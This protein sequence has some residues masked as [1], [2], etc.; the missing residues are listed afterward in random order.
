MT[1]IITSHTKL[2]KKR[3]NIYKLFILCPITCSA[4]S[5]SHENNRDVEF[6]GISNPV[7]FFSNDIYLPD[8]PKCEIH[9]KLFLVNWIPFLILPIGIYESW[10][11][12]SD[13]LFSP[14]K[15]HGS[16][17]VMPSK[18]QLWSMLHWAM[19]KTA[20][21]SVFVDGRQCMLLFVLFETIPT[22][23]CKTL[24]LLLILQVRLISN[25]PS[26]QIF[27]I[28]VYLCAWQKG[29]I[30]SPIWSK[31]IFVSITLKKQNSCMVS[32]KPGMINQWSLA[33]RYLSRDY[34][35][36]WE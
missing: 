15:T 30:M 19:H 2:L 35:P 17:L 32:S 25:W 23:K 4:I 6:P 13:F 31:E 1:Q 12:P 34:K 7:H 3:L 22:N 36:K 8:A 24:S 16:W 18:H 26:G 29:M 14:P 10:R 9:P 11:R 21:L 20:E 27:I 33:P 5:N 28:T